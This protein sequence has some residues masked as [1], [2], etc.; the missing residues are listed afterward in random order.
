MHKTLNLIILAAAL[1]VVGCVEGTL[2]DVP[3]S[4]DQ[5]RPEA[6]RH[7]RISEFR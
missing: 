6:T 7:F 1:F 2:E 3:V 5:E 4:A